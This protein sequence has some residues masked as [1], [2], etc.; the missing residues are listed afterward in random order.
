MSV[1]KMSKPGAESSRRITITEALSHLPGPQGERSAALFER[2]DVQVKIYAPRGRDPQTPH[3]RDEIYIVA[4]GR[5]T[6]FN[7]QDR[8]PFEPGDFLFVQ[9]G[10]EH[11][12][13][14][15]TDDLVVWVVFFGPQTQLRA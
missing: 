9:A 13:E 15:F 1:S 8:R 4:Q 12:F 6:F 2:R 10:V 11:R 3:T 7:G 14:D 5:G